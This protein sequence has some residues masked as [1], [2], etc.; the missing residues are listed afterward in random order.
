MLRFCKGIYTNLKEIAKLSTTYKI[1][2]QFT[3]AWEY[4]DN[5]VQGKSCC[6]DSINDR[7]EFNMV[8]GA[9]ETLNFTEEECEAVWGVVA[10]VLH[11]GN[12]TFTSNDDGH[13]TLT[14][15]THA[16]HCSKVGMS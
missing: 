10:A 3:N 8:R 4:D 9:L 1:I 12:I 2:N 13:A 15:P 6:V 7:A 16:E 14:D 5:F 11:L